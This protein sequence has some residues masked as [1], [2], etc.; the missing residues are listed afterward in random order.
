MH[1]RN[2]KNQ[3]P[4]SVL[5]FGCMRFARKGNGIDMD[6]TQKQILLA[7]ERGVNYFDT[8]YIYPG[9]EAALGEIL[10]RT[11][12]RDKVNIAT[13]LPQYL[14]RNRAGIDKY[15]LEELGRLKTDHV[16]YYLMHMLTDLEAWNKLVK[17][18]IEDWIRE[19]KESGAIR[20]IG[21]SFHGN[22]EMFIRILHAYD[23]DFCQVQ[24]N[25]MDEYSQ[26]GREGVGEAARLGIPVIIME[27]LRGGK[28]V[29]LLPAKAKELIAADPKG[30]SA[31]ELAFSWLWNQPQV[32]TVLSG[33]NTLEMVEENCRIADKAVPG[34]LA[35]EDEELV[36]KVRALIN[37][38]LL[39]GCTGCGYCMPCPH[40]VDIPGAFRCYN[41]MSMESKSVGRNEYFQVVSLRKKPAFPS[42]CVGCGRC[43]KHCPQHISIIEELKKADRALRPFPYRVASMVARRFALKS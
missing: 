35:P 41:E 38:K 39:V 27:P 32:T 28:L 42:Q 17:L 37:E 18:G 22:T 23:W 30:R 13:K 19:K 4:L 1:Y 2:N 8:A 31:A 3:E 29:S 9:S 15:F 12:M 16:D 11:G 36:D 25:Y 14:I 43:E 24:Y 26:A 10:S 7:I 20:N 21:F 40:G 33:M 6:E 34:M 5:G